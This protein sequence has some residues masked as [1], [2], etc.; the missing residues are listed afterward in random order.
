M[1]RLRSAAPL[2]R[3]IRVIA[4]SARC[5]RA[6]SSAAAEL[7]QPL[8][9]FVR[10][11]IGSQEAD[12]AKM[13][14]T[15]GV[16]NLEELT[17]AVIPNSIRFNKD[18]EVGRFPVRGETEFLTE[19]KKIASLNHSNMKSLIGMGYVASRSVLDYCLYCTATTTL[20]P[21]A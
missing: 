7:R 14:Q 21:P 9:T 17:S 20:K 11:H 4:A 5:A 18:L 10:R 12:I 6:N 15:V 8:D 3:N 19:L 2:L 13:M 1:L 16:K